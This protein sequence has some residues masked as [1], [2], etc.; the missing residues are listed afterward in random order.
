VRKIDCWIKIFREI[1]QIT[2]I[3]WSEIVWTELSKS[4]FSSRRSEHILS[5]PSLEAPN[6]RRHED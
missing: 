4:P 3:C 5:F 6:I 1:E 2:V